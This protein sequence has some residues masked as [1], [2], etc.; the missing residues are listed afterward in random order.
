MHNEVINFLRRQGVHSYQEIR[1]LLFFCQHPDFAG[2]YHQ[3]CERL[4]LGDCAMLEQIIRRFQHNGLIECHEGR[5]KL[6]DKPDVKA[7]LE[8]LAI[9]FDQ[10]LS[11]Q[12]LLASV[13]RLAM[14]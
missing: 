7:R 13:I 3:F 12:Q 6:V 8:L 11:R 2:T 5:Y 4:Y 9:A 10:P 14:N 1:L